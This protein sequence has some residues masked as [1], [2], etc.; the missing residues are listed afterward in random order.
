MSFGVL[1]SDRQCIV[2]VWG[3][4]VEVT[5]EILHG[6]TSLLKH[7]GHGLYEGLPQNFPVTRYHSLA[8]MKIDL[9]KCL[10]I[11]SWTASQSEHGEPII[12]GVRHK[13]LCVEGVQFHPESI[14]TAE[15][16]K[17]FINF[18]KRTAGRWPLDGLQQE[19]PQRN[20]HEATNGENKT[21][22]KSTPGFKSSS[23]ILSTIFEH[24]MCNV[25][26]Q[27]ERPGTRFKD[28][29]SAIEH[30][31]E[32][33]LI[34]FAD[35]LSR[36]K[37]PMAL[38]AEIKRASPSKGTIDDAI[39]ASEQALKYAR[40]GASVISVLTESGWFK[41]DIEDLKAVRKCF[42]GISDRPAILR[43]DFIYD[44][45]QILEAR[46]AGADTV[47]LIVKMLETV[48]LEELYHYSKSLGME[49]LVE[50][51][52]VE[53]MHTAVNLGSK[54]IGV[55]NRNLNSFE[56]DLSTTS[57]L[58]SLAPDQTIICALSG[59]SNAEDIR[60]YSGT[61]VRAVLIGESL[62]RADNLQLYT[63]KLFG[64]EHKTNHMPSLLTKICGTRSVEAAK[65]AVK[66]GADLVGM[67]L[68]GGRKRSVTTEVALQISQ[69]VKSTV[70]P[71]M[72]PDNA[73]DTKSAQDSYTNRTRTSLHHPTR[74]LIVGV[75]QNQPLDYILKMQRLLELDIV[76]LHGS[77]PIEWASLVP[78]P[79]IRS[80]KPEE[81][82]IGCKGYHLSLLDSSDG[83]AGKAH[84]IEIVKSVL[85][86]DRSIN[87]ILAGGLNPENVSE[88]I[89]NLNEFREQ[90]IGVDVS[91][92]IEVEGLQ[93]N[94][95]IIRFVH[96]AKSA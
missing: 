62:M 54:V 21:S 53:E 72:N 70:R 29:Q 43:K 41:G 47:L 42:V 16:R 39:S 10:E 30:G 73:L 2:S 3:G 86:R 94:E 71:H 82:G 31:L 57:N 81:I 5:G 40:C 8:G 69:A 20:M 63:S 56:V 93:N 61:G 92:G 34:P 19:M 49:P 36:S 50:V 83:G 1:I 35:R 4:R 13:N 65:V 33:P 75:F 32:P 18:L 60:N 76:Q 85:A 23:S 58:M 89:Q 28:L 27:K 12:M 67:I 37:F 7:D 66:S 95:K 25:L 80:F 48:V 84:D 59:I 64:T 45:Y 91:S 78:V 87:I 11:S 88:T 17:I 96:A 24:K 14:T 74:A 26:M 77:E 6:K 51:N 46:L 55:N 79:V 44:Q 38:M 68:V 9:P 22:M 15:G 52:T 90:I